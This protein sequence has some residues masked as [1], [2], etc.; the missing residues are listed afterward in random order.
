MFIPVVFI[1]GFAGIF[2]KEMAVVVS[3]ALLCALVVS[4]SLIP[5]AA[6]KW[7]GGRRLRIEGSRLLRRVTVLLRSLDQWYADHVRLWLR[8]PKKV[9]VGALLLLF[10]SFFLG[11]MIGFELMPEADEGR[12]NASIELPVGTPV[13]TTMKVMQ[14]LELALRQ[15]IRPEEL[16]HIVTTAGPENWYRPAAGNQGS[17]EIMLVPSTQRQRTVEQVLAEARRVAEGIPAVR[18]RIYPSSSNMMMRMMR[19]GGERLTVEIRGHDLATADRLGPSGW[20]P[21]WGRSRASLTR[22]S[23]AKTASSSTPFTSIVAGWPSSGSRGPTSPPRSRPMCSGAWP[24]AIASTATSTTSGCSFARP[25][26]R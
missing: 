10:A 25:T 23:I 5:A 21:P 12:I 24:L 1:Q 19:G 3:F 16:E 15:A 20:W 17:M 6:A 9:V 7:L 8:H 11:P 2:F 14:E 4:M 26:A 13:E 18:A 22:A